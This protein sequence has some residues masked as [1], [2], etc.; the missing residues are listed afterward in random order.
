MHTSRTV[1][2]IAEQLGVDSER[3]DLYIYANFKA[4]FKQPIERRMRTANCVQ[5]F[6]PDKGI[7]YLGPDFIKVNR[8]IIVN[9][10]YESEEYKGCARN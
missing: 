4:Y 6:H 9:K 2:W 5:Y 8:K 1:E 7:I 3:L 10:G